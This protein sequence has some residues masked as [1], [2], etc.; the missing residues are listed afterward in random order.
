MPFLK[1]LSLLDSM[2]I[3]LD[4]GIRTLAGK[5]VGTGRANPAQH[6][7]N[8]P[9][10]KNEQRHAAGLM[11]I[12]QTG[13]I[14]AQALYQ[15]QALTARNLEIRDIMQ[16]AAIEENDHLLWCNERVKELN[17]YSSLFNP[18]WY[19]SSLGLGILAGIWGDKWSLGFLAETEKQ[20]SAHLQTHL[21]QLPS[22]DHKSRAIVHQMW[23]DETE[24]ADMAIEQGGAELPI[25]LKIIMKLSARIMT[26]IVY[27]I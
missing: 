6:I 7:L 10:S 16:K 3:H 24:H 13:E 25:P 19:I 12:N 27:Y 11:R 20:V 9:L 15:G 26:K 5:P 23:E 2:V 17:S 1:T 22:N 4:Q 8:D 21:D 18:L 14:A